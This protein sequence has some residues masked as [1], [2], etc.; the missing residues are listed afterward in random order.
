MK[1]SPIYP[2]KVPCKIGIIP[3]TYEEIEAQSQGRF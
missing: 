2:L 1:E 3:F